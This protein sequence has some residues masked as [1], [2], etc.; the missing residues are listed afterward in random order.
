MKQAGADAFF[1]GRTAR[2]FAQLLVIAL[3]FSN[4]A[5]RAADDLPADFYERVRR[6][7]IEV[8]VDDHLDGSGWIAE[9]EGIVVTAAHVVNTPGKRVEVMSPIIGRMEAKVIA[10]DRGNDTAVLKL[11]PREGGYPVLAFADRKSVV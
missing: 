3:A 5:S 4:S 6:A 10:I 2:I 7:C 11:P 9:A 1:F 8:L